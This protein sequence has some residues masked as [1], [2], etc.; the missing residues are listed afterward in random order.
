VP[1]HLLWGIAAAPAAGQNH[2]SGHFKMNLLIQINVFQHFKQSNFCKK[3]LIN[4][5]L[6]WYT[7]YLLLNF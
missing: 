1:C 4:L 3:I 7:T 5:Q 2:E 6:F